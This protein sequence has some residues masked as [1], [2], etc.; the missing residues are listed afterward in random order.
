MESAIRHGIDAFTASLTPS[1][2][3]HSRRDLQRRYRMV[4]WAVI[5]DQ[6][7]YLETHIHEGSWISGAYYVS[8]PAFKKSPGNDHPGAPGAIEFG[9]PSSHYGIESSV[10]TRVVQA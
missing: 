7:G 6:E 10:S 2:E 5:L 1:P 9:R 4:M 8:I 3:H